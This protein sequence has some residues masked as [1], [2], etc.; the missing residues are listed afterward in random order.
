MIA[1][2]DLKPYKFRSF[3]TGDRLVL[4]GLMGGCRERQG[5]PSPGGLS[6]LGLDRGRKLEESMQTPALP[7]PGIKP[8][9]SSAPLLHYYI[10][11]C[12]NPQCLQKCT[13]GKCFVYLAAGGAAGSEHKTRR[14]G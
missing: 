11:R 12:L 4:L 14:S 3:S 8:S 13:A 10:I 7:G 6:C 2:G 1:I 9:T 5:P